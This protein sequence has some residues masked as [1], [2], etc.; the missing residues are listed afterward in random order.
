MQGLEGEEKKP[1]CYILEMKEPMEGAKERDVVISWIVK[2][3]TLSGC[4]L[5]GVEARKQEDLV[6]LMGTKI[7]LCL[8]CHLPVSLHW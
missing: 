3:D 2:A 6:I 7:Y 4:V 8:T 5:D 1:E